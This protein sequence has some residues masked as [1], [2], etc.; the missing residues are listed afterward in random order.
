MAT[1]LRPGGLYRDARGRWKDAE[2][3]TAEPPGEAPAGDDPAGDDPAGDDP[4][5]GAGNTLDPTDSAF[6]TASEAGVEIKTIAEHAGKTRIT[7]ADVLRY[8]KA[9]KDANGN[10]GE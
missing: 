4:A 1:A 9:H 6:Q 7:K 10:E 2:G 8:V 3:R 5:G